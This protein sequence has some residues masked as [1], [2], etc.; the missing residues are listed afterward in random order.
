MN[1]FTKGPRAAT[2]WVALLQYTQVNDCKHDKKPFSY[3]EPGC[4]SPQP[5]LA[6]STATQTMYSLKSSSLENCIIP[7]EIMK[8]FERK[9]RV[10]I[11]WE[12]ISFRPLLFS[13]KENSDD[14]D[15]S[16]SI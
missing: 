10:Q 5:V 8:W 3:R 4:W 2:L 7:D 6:L 14:M 12:L 1:L 13:E 9:H 11:P 15:N 16:G